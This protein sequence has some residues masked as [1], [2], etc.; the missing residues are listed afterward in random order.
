MPWKDTTI[1]SLRLEFVTLALKEDANLSQLCKRF[2]ISRKTGYKW[3]ERF[4]EEG[5]TGLLD[6]SRRPHYSPLRTPKVVE[7]AVLKLRDEHPSWGGRKIARRLRVL[8]VE[9]V[10][11]P[12]TITAILRRN[13]RL[14]PEEARKHQPYKRFEADAPN[15]LWQMDFKGYFTLSRGG[16][17]YPLTVLD[18]HSRYAL[19]LRACGGMK[20][21]TVKDELT[22]IFR[23]YGI[24]ERF[25]MDNGGPWGSGHDHNYTPLTA[26]FI[27]LGI[28]AI[29]S[30]PYHPQTL[31]KDER[32]HRTIQIE[33]LQGR[34]FHDL[35]HAQRHFDPW[36]DVYN[37][38]RP[39]EALD[40]DVPASRYQESPRAFP[41]VLPPIEY[42]PDDI[43]RKVQDKG[44]VFFRGRIFLIP[45]AFRGHLV[46]LRPTI[47]DG[48]Y[49]VH[50]CQ[51]KVADIDLNKQVLDP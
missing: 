24:P 27:R 39:H 40:M 50:F 26:W 18:D 10:P 31:G 23:R 32:F 4:L 33:L 43:I 45:S 15:D 1:V 25:L 36:R 41:E 48:H 9:G 3:L 19:G 34:L 42:G 5:P 46:A 51:Q 16:R 35:H 11:A 30:R 8:G 38:E 17:C 44:Q 12:S 20:G 47:K 2:G 28:T 22:A 13:D 37:F 29:H 21:K 7:Q 14:D 49:E 6:R